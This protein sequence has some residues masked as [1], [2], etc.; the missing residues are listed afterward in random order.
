MSKDNQEIIDN[1]KEALR[2]KEISQEQYESAVLLAMTNE[3]E[4]DLLNRSHD[5]ESGTR[6]AESEG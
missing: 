3:A 4:N 6:T 2:N 5:L 1:A